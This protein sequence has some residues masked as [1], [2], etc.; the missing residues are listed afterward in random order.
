MT[1]GTH[2]NERAKLEQSGIDFAPDAIKLEPDALDHCLFQLAHRDTAAKIGNIGGRG[3]RIDR[4]A[5]QGQTAGLC[6]WIFLGKIGG[7]GK[8][9]WHGLADGDYMDIWSETAHEI[10]SVE[11]IILDVELTSAHG[12]V[13]GI[14]PVGHIDFTIRDQADDG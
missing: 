14:V 10:H 1:F 5:N 13:A 11:G 9:K 2:R 7:G 3:I 8:D 4:T 6:V 12:D